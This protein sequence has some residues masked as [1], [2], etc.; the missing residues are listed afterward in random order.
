LGSCSV[1]CSAVEGLKNKTNSLKNSVRKFFGDPTTTNATR[2]HAGASYTASVAV[3]EAKH[4]VITTIHPGA[5][6]QTSGD[7]VIDAA[8][9]QNGR[10]ICIGGI[11]ANKYTSAAVSVGLAVADYTNTALVNIGEQNAERVR[12]DAKNSNET[13]QP[14]LIITKHMTF[15]AGQR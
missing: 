9:A 3:A 15:A 4:T 6:L 14:A 13:H 11:E 8:I 1:P 5:V 10:V 7:L 12:L 2:T